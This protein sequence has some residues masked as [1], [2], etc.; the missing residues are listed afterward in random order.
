MVTRWWCALVCALSMASG[1][2]VGPDYRPPETQVP[3]EWSGGA[4]ASTQPAGPATQPVDLAVWWQSLGDEQLN[5]LIE[6]SA[7]SNL[8]LQQAAARVLE[9]RASRDIAR[10]DFWPQLNLGGSYSYQRRSQNSL[11]SSG[12]DGGVG[13]SVL[14][15]LLGRTTVLPPGIDPATGAVVPPEVA[16]NADRSAVPLSTLLPEPGSGIRRDQN[17]FQLGFDASWEIDLWGRIR[18]QV[19]AAGA[20]QASFEESARDVMVILF[21][22]VARNYIELRG[23]QRRL[24]I[25][26]ENIATQQDTL[27][28]TRD[29]LRAGFTTELDEAQARTQLESTQSQVPVFETTIR[30]SIYAL[31]V[32]LGQPPG[33]LVG[34]L[35][36]PGPLPRRA[37]EVPIGLP[38]DLLR[39]RPDI[40]SAERALAA[41][42]ARIGVATAELFPQ[43]SLTGSFGTQSAEMKHFLD[44]RSLFWSVGPSVQW[45]IFTAGRIQANIRAEEARQAQALAGYGSTVLAAFRDVENAL[46]AYNQELTRRETLVRAV[47]ASRLAARLS[48]ELY[49]R[50]L[51]PFLNVLEAQRSLYLTQD[52]LVLS[53]TALMTNLVSLYKALGGGWEG[54]P[55]VP[56][57]QAVALEK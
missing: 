24:Q 52:E 33:A 19:E 11:P 34:E 57:A 15:G 54:R 31:S 18:R 28:I 23:A 22:E 48:N 36:P 56:P 13:R 44:Q 21:A 26:R 7:Q 53:E 35:G 55:V 3:S 5:S 43:L 39:R 47:E 4:V 46:V 27:E 16:V 41:S 45:P 50:G 12:G 9:A 20:D 25:A 10:A 51:G 42:T 37:P 38:A 40:R 30:Q 32:L 1:C 8:D 49:T 17:L 6:R 14:D 2:L 29:R